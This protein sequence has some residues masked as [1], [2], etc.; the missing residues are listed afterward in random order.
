MEHGGLKGYC[1]DMGGEQNRYV[2]PVAASTG[3]IGFVIIAMLL[4]GATFPVP[5]FSA[6]GRQKLVTFYE[7]DREMTCSFK[8]ELAI[9]PE[10][11][12]LGLMF[13]ES[14]E[15]DKGM[16]FIFERD[17]PRVFW[18]KNTYIPLDLVFINAALE[19]VHIHHSA[20]PRDE[21]TM[22]SKFGARYVLE[23]K[24]GKARACN[25]SRGIKARFTDASGK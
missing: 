11:Q 21:T 24:A 14:L 17:E 23:V 22:H 12:S 7:K 19:V 4:V 2:S 25:I 9:T 20:M 18:M 5:V 10:E 13:R 6:D 1:A 15:P 8:A 3:L 16:L